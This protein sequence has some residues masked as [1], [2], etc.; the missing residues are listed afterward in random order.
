MFAYGS[1]AL[2]SPS[3]FIQQIHVFVSYL[4]RQKIYYFISSVVVRNKKK[5]WS[6]YGISILLSDKQSRFRPQK[7]SKTYINEYALHYYLIDIDAIRVITKS[8]RM[9]LI[10]ANRRQFHITNN[11]F[12]FNK[13]NP[14]QTKSGSKWKISRKIYYALS[15]LMFV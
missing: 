4:W 9:L 14:N 1:I 3:Y 10:V 6:L 5:Y 13:I 15:V 7:K 12:V 8:Q 11:I 2:A